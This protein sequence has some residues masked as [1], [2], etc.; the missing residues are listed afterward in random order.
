MNHCFGRCSQA[1]LVIVCV[2]PLMT[3]Q[4][5]LQSVL[6]KVFTSGNDANSSGPSSAS[7]F[8]ILGATGEIIKQ[9]TEHHLAAYLH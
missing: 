5:T 3:M 1:T 8:S 4:V 7:A 9:F 6:L 2:Q